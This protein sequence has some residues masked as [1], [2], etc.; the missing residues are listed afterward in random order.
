MKRLLFVAIFLCV[1][2][3]VCLAQDE[4]AIAVVQLLKTSSSWDG[5]ALPTYP[6]GKPEITIARVTIPPG[7]QLPLHEHPVI[8]AGVV[9]SGGLTIVREDGETFRVSA[10][11]AFAEV[12]NRGHS[13]RNDGDIPVEIV[14]F[15]AGTV[16]SPVTV[17]K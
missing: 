17:N 13:G 11:E 9:L 12:V 2:P 15:Y 10:G 5:S 3:A 7:A 16:D 1:L 6:E 14:A 8:T 4:D